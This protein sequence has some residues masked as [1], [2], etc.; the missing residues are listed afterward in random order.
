M[1]KVTIGQHCVNLIL[2]L[3]EHILK[4]ENNH[5]NATND[6]KTNDRAW[7]EETLRLCNVTLNEINRMKEL[8]KINEG[9][10]ERKLFEL[11]IE[12]FNL[13]KTNHFS[14]SIIIGSVRN[15]SVEILHFSGHDKIEVIK[16]YLN[17]GL[18]YTE[19]NEHAR[20]Y[21]CYDSADKLLQNY[22]K[23]KSNANE[24]FSQQLNNL[25]NEIYYEQAKSLVK[26]K[27]DDD[28]MKCFIV[29]VK[30]CMYKL[31]QYL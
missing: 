16:L 6:G 11:G 10:V 1:A 14:S 23:Q 22:A 9:D 13:T 5:N 3:K 25:Q 30:V 20:A 12:L 27:R 7:E 19:S 15:I 17:T 28:A 2:S 29:Y 26:L 8:V 4:H 31:F 21:N 18:K 24:T